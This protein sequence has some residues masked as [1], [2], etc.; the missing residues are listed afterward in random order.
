M[1]STGSKMRWRL[2]IPIADTEEGSKFIRNTSAIAIATIVREL[3]AHSADVNI[4]EF[5]EWPDLVDTLLSL[6]KQHQNDKNPVVITS[7][8][9]LVHLLCHGLCPSHYVL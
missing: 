6:L 3:H 2:N 5:D 8:L 7:I 4:T 9:N 1:R